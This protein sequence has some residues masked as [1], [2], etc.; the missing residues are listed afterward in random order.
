M[1]VRDIYDAVLEF[2]EDRV[3]ELVR[4]ELDAGS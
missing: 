3:A 1:A 2:D 4:A